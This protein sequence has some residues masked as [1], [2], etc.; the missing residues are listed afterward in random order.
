[1]SISDVVSEIPLNLANNEMNTQ[2][3]KETVSVGEDV[4]MDFLFAAYLSW[5]GA[6]FLH[7]M[8]VRH[9]NEDRRRPRHDRQLHNGC[10]H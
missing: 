9:T 2:Q 1:M 5:Q 8:R 4:M 3:V 6:Q 10:L 7:E